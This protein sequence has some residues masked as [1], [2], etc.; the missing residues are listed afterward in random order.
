MKSNHYK[1]AFEHE[2]I[3]QKDT[4]SVEKPLSAVKDPGVYWVKWNSG[5]D[6]ELCVM[7]PSGYV[8]E[9]SGA[10]RTLPK[11]RIAGMVVGPVLLWP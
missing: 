8:Q 9:I 7:T 5:G 2:D 1:K 3:V 11:D 10:R 4:A 6:W